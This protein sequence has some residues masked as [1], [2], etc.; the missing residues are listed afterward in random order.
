MSD[1]A[2][3]FLVL[4]ALATVSTFAGDGQAMESACAINVGSLRVCW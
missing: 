4:I 1:V 3:A 2:A